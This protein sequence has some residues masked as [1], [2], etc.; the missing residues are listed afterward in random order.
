M[1]CVDLLA[2][3][4]RGRDII[5][6]RFLADV[7]KCFFAFLAVLG[8]IRSGYGPGSPVQDKRKC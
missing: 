4:I 5:V 1:T 6:K 7:S 2:R 8:Y 3:Q